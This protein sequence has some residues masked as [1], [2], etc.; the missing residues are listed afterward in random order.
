LFELG[1]AFCLFTFYFKSLLQTKLPAGKF[2][3]NIKRGGNFRMEILIDNP[4]ATMYGPFF[5]IFFGFIIFFAV[6]ILALVKS[7]FDKTDRLG[8]PSIPPNIDPF[9][10]AYLRGGINEVVRSVIFSL[11][12]KGFFEI[13]YSATRYY[14]KR[15]ANPPNKSN[16]STIEL[17]TYEWMS[18]SH[19]PREL[20]SDFGLAYHLE[21]FRTTYQARLE[22]QQMLT[23]EADRKV[24]GPVKWSVYGLI[25]SLGG[26]KLF[27]AVANGNFNFI[28]LIIF[29]IVGLLIARSVAKLPRLTKLGEAYLSR[30]QTAFDNLKYTSQS[31]YIPS[32]EPRI[33]PQTTFAGVDPLLLSVGVFGSGILVGTVFDS[34][35]HAF[36]R[37]QMAAS[38]GGGSSCGSGGCGSS[39]SSGSGGSSCSSGSS[40]GGGC[41]GCGGGCS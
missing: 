15:S 16:L 11:V 23:S 10:I 29:M 21:S 4:L 41:G 1:F 34:Y 37:S 35:N 19:E 33:V 2:V 13:E 31:A 20:F 6:I 3:Y 28:L 30:L 32:K 39:C 24:F 27:A 5:L 7:Q 17:K 25:L 8:I 18:A 22:Q 9:E 14:V 12:Q 38:S 26:Y 36:Q 40:C